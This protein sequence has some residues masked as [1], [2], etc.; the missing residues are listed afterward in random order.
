M[1]RSRTDGQSG[2]LWLGQIHTGEL[3]W[4]EGVKACG[5]WMLRGPQPQT[6]WLWGSG[7]PLQYEATLTTAEGAPLGRKW[8]RGGVEQTQPAKQGLA[9]G[10]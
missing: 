1:G 5:P 10:R 8:V 7:E 4:G 3:V 6:G 9:Q 2:R